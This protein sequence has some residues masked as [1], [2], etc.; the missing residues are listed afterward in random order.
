MEPYHLR[1]HDKA[2]TSA[3]ELSRILSTVRT[4]S[5]A[6]CADNEPYLVILNHGWDRERSCLYFHCAPKGKK[7][8]ILLKNPRV[9][10]V[11]VEDLGYLDGRCDH[12]YRSVMFDGTVSFLESEA[13]KLQALEI[14]IRQH[15]SDPKAVI[16]DQLTSKRVAATTIGRINIDRITGKE[17]LP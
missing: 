16:A 1:R 12:A 4:V 5:L 17:A 13:E 6:M 7:I 9:W 8:D 11:A 10:G 15:E 14:M 3:D 2:L